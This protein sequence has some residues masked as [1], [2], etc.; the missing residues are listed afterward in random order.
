MSI[1]CETPV[2]KKDLS[3]SKTE[4]LSYGSKSKDPKSEESKKTDPA[5]SE[6]SKGM[7]SPLVGGV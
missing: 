1:R 4:P 3:E 2:Y 6:A 5:S 7:H